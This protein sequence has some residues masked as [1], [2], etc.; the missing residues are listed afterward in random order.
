MRKYVA[1]C[2][3]V[4]LVFS[5]LAGC[6]SPGSV[7]TGDSGDAVDS[8]A[9]GDAGN[10]VDTG[11]TVDTGDAGDTGKTGD[12]GNP[13]DAEDDGKWKSTCY[14]EDDPEADGLPRVYM[15]SDISPEGLMAVYEAL[16]RPAEG[17]TAIK[18]HM[19]EPGNTNYVSPD[20]IKDLVLSVD[21]T[22]VDCNTY[23]GGRRTQ[24]EAHIQA[25][26]DHGFTY[27][28][29]DI[30]DAEG[31][32][33]LPIEGGAR[34]QEAIVGSHYP[35]YDF[36]ISIAHFKG[37]ELAGFGGAFKNIAVGIAS[38]NGKKAIHDE[39]GSYMFSTRGDAFLEKIV[40]TAKA[41]IDDKGE[42]MVYIN[43]V[44]NLSVD[45][46]CNSHPQRA[47]MSDIGILASLDPV[48]L[49]KACVDLIYA[50][51]EDERRELV[52]R[53]ESKNGLHLLAYA[54]QLGLGSQKYVLVNLDD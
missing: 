21:G 8:G 45:C 24:T 46:D 28:P 50:A 34:L 22:F 29:I 53:I 13:G 51:P 31:E 49:D 16:G 6:G 27:A 18:I 43:V 1:L 39:P 25:A 7:N 17:K 36:I 3:A 11:N 2:L 42:K 12:S 14:S 54:E 30:L 20:L 37:H 35:D 26:K 5:L 4:F 38:V 10:V 32:I 40:E 47:K 19:G 52:W 33:K 41:I 9:A 23:Y 15:T 48:A 44:N